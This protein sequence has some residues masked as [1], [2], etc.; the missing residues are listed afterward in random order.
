MAKISKN[1]KKIAVCGNIGVGKTSIV[2]QLSKLQPES[3]PIYEKFE[4]NPYQPLFY[5]HLNSEVTPTDNFYNKYCYPTQK[6]FQH[7]RA[8]NE[9]QHSYKNTIYI[10]D[11]S[12][13]EDR[14]IFAENQIQTGLMSNSEFEEYK[15]EYDRFF[16]QIKKPDVVIQLKV[17]VDVLLSRIRNRNREMEET[18]SREYLGKLNE[19]YESEFVERKF[20]GSVLLDYETGGVGVVDLSKKIVSDLMDLDL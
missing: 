3:N 7:T 2:T 11:R 19:L 6:F 16:S 10:F 1:I 12:L 8:K 15:I 9:L 13:Y 5:K 20:D 4:K 17:N 18:I 14:Y